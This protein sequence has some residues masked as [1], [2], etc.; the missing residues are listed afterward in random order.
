MSEQNSF[1][2]YLVFGLLVFV[3]FYLSRCNNDKPIDKRKI[4]VFFPGVPEIGNLQPEKKQFFFTNE[5]IDL[6][7]PFDNATMDSMIGYDIV[8]LNLS[9]NPF[10][11]SAVYKASFNPSNE[12]NIRTDSYNGYM[13]AFDNYFSF[14][15]EKRFD[16]WKDLWSVNVKSEI[17]EF[18]SLKA[19]QFV[20]LKSN[21]MSDTEVPNE[22]SQYF[23]DISSARNAIQSF[24]KRGGKNVKLYLY[25]NTD[26][27]SKNTNTGGGVT[28]IKD[29]VV[30]K[31]GEKPKEKKKV[32]ALEQTPNFKKDPVIEFRMVKPT[33]E[34][35]LGRFTWRSSKIEDNQLLA[36]HNPPND[37]QTT[38]TITPPHNND[39]RMFKLTPETNSF[40]NISASSPDWDYLKEFGSVNVDISFFSESAGIKESMNLGKYVFVCISGGICK[41][42][43]PPQKL[44]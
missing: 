39:R 12:N 32:V 37:L 34:L 43:P 9:N 6:L 26:N 19:N 21:G 36:G 38:I 5:V 25:Y 41:L 8:E 13:T 42:V 17:D 4:E 20:V 10:F 29:K 30:E 18:P 28:I 11:G 23:Q 35:K 7:S 14:D 1:V 33:Y 3:V 2:K 22:E 24:L 31:P 27:S 44:N 16:E 15:S 40:P